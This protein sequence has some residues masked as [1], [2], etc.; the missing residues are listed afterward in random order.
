MPNRRLVGRGL[1]SLTLTAFVLAVVTAS[2]GPGPSAD[3]A[4][5]EQLERETYQGTVEPGH[6]VAFVV[7]P[8]KGVVELI[9]ISDNTLEAPAVAAV[10]RAPN[11]LQDDLREAFRRMD[12]PA[13]QA[14]AAQI[15]TAKAHLVDELAFVTAH[16]SAKDRTYATPQ[17]L[18]QNAELIY[19]VDPELH[20][21]DLV[22]HGTLGTDADYYTSIKYQHT[23]D[24]KAASYELP[25]DI[26]YWWVVHPVLA[27][28]PLATVDPSSG[29]LAAPPV[30][31]T[32]REYMLAT[33][34]SKVSPR[35]HFIAQ[36]PN[37]ITD[38]D[39]KTWD[40][41]AAKAHGSLRPSEVG[42]NEVI[43][44]G[45]TH[46]PVLIQ[47]NPTGW[48]CCT[49]TAD[50]PMPDGIYIAT[51]IPVERAALNGNAELLENLIWAGPGRMTMRDL[52]IVSHAPLAKETRKF[53][54]VRDQLPFG[55]AKDPNEAA[56]T[57]MGRSYDVLTSTQLAALISSGKLSSASKP[58]INLTY[59]KIIVP[60]DQP[61]ALYKVLASNRVAIEAF[62]K[63]GG[64]FQLHGAAAEANDWSDLT[65]PGGI[66]TTK[67]TS[68]G[69]LDTLQIYG[70][71]LLRDVMKDVKYLWDGVRRCARHGA[72]STCPAGDR[73]LKAGDDAI[74]RVGWWQGQIV[75]RCVQEYRTFHG[76]PVG[77]S[78]RSSFPQRI[79]PLHFGNCGEIS[80]VVAAASRAVLIPSM[81][82]RGALDH[83]WNEFYT[84]D[85]VWYPYDT[86]Y[87]DSPLKVGDWSVSKDFDTRKYGKH[88][89]ALL[90][91]RGDGQIVNLLGRTKLQTEKDGMIDFE[92]TR[93]LE[94]QIKVLDAEKNPVDGAVVTLLSEY[95]HSASVAERILFGV[96]DRQGLVRMRVG[97]KRNFYVNIASP[98]GHY[99]QKM[100]LGTQFPGNSEFKPLITLDQAVEG[101]TITK[102]FILAGKDQ[103][104]QAYT[105]AAIPPATKVSWPAPAKD[106][107]YHRVELDLSLPTE[108]RPGLS[109]LSQRVFVESVSPGAADLYLTDAANYAL[110]KAGKS[111]KAA[112]VK[113]G[114]GAVDRLIVDLPDSSQEWYVIV[115]NKRRLA[116]AERV[117]ATLTLLQV[118]PAKG[119]TSEEPVDQG[120]CSC[121]V[122]AR[123]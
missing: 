67:Q 61:Y 11:W 35:E 89:P 17:L 55:A 78:P 56:V 53:L 90:A 26:Y 65:L 46:E 92:Y 74:D 116:F 66:K 68:S 77:G 105:K 108:F 24:G 75:D 123:Q 47:Y 70:N 27:Q 99:P 100:S 25:R 102:E 49:S 18:L 62:V 97:D 39:L 44:A 12:A 5:V 95:Y 96:T 50:Y 59:N 120:G 10:K 98:V 54:I 85:G 13:R 69:Y 93:H 86:G 37:T 111:F 38:A 22:E 7:K 122:G 1:T 83:T 34:A 6:H 118:T 88:N 32:W 76:L 117:K 15:N 16:L 84:P 29:K 33:M 79:A 48:S 109:P 58:W 64:V 57:K 82:V 23:K 3:D 114:V 40:F 119:S 42:A 8:A 113:E 81:W 106:A 101:A 20:Y 112:V 110:Y 21:A 36:Q 91:F 71:A 2:F 43:R 73:K 19:A 60:S 51:T 52:D 4:K 80:Y 9:E 121:R 28:E 104:G 107:A 14:Y 103:A 30:G 45:A 63:S 41:G 31:V 72:T 115:S 87:S 94:L